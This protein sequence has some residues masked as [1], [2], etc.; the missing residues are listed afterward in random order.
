MFEP[1]STTTIVLLISFWISLSIGAG[2]IA[3]NKGRSFWKTFCLGGFTHPF[4]AIIIATQF[5]RKEKC[6]FCLER[7]FTEAKTCKCCGKDKEKPTLTKELLSE[8][9]FGKESD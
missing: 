8:L 7:I 2:K 5:K 1:I 4:I 9:G 3:K 6:E